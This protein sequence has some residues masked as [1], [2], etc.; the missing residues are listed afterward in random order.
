[1]AEV[2]T[3]AYLGDIEVNY[4]NLYLGNNNSFINPTSFVPIYAIRN[5]AFSASLEFAFPGT[6]A[7]NLGMNSY[8]DDIALIIKGTGNARSAQPTGSGQLYP[9]QSLVSSGSYNWS[10]NGY[11]TSLFIS[12]AKN[13]TSIPTQSL[14]PFGSNT[15]VF[16]G[17]FNYKSPISPSVAPFNQFFFGNIS[18]DSVLLNLSGPDS[19]RYAFY[20]NGPGNAIIKVASNYTQDIWYHL[21]FVR[22]A[23]SQSIYLNGQRI[24]NIVISNGSVPYAA[25]QTDWDVLGSSGLNDGAAKLAQDVRLYIGTDKNYT[26]SVITPPESMIYSL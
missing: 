9:S 11:Q 23:T 16:E 20:L 15:F 25:G 18:G 8:N 24:S 13:L 1:M 12:G 22:N 17:W 21:A 7:S 6:L 4:A 10:N 3:L 5:D 26:A 19:D 2:G 14:G